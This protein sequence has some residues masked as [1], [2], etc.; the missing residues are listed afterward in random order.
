MRNEKILLVDD[1]QGIL[2][3]FNILLKKEGFK[4]IKT[5]TS[6][7][8]ALSIVK[9]SKLDLIILDVS[10]PDM[11]GFQLCS[12]IRLYTQIPILFVSARSSDLDK[13]TG[14]G[15]GGD[16]Y[17]TKPF[18][19][20]E[21]MARIH[22]QL[23]RQNIYKASSQ[24]S[25]TTI[26]DYG[27]LIVYPDEGRIIVNGE[28]IP[29]TAKEFELLTF[30]CKHPNRIFTTNQLYETVWGYSY[31]GD[32]KTVVMHISKLRKKIELNP[33]KPQIIVNLRGLGYKF[34]PPSRGDQ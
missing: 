34:I 19:P 21:V 32:E 5:A 8:E 16:D 26:W 3:I 10:L 9:N 13:L 18:H 24:T 25:A 4:E 14:F 22:A 6:G 23:R 11:D 27:S 30:F 33:K 15:I 29:H 1:E 17:I 2:D 31:V 7:E 12:Q 20:L 28:E